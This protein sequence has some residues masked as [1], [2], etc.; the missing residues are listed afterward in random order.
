LQESETLLIMDN[1]T[2]LNLIY[3]LMRKFLFWGKQ[4]ITDRLR[5]CWGSYW[6]CR[7]WNKS[8]KVQVGDLPSHQC[9]KLDV[10]MFFWR[11]IFEGPS[12]K[13]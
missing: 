8:R 2:D 10:V 3:W 6:Q 4:A 5:H 7:W 12:I 1:K 13:F 9:N 11:I